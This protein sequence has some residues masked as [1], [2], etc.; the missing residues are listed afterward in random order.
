MRI[1]ISRP[2][3]LRKG[4]EPGLRVYTVG[5]LLCIENFCPGERSRVYIRPDELEVLHRVIESLMNKFGFLED[6][7][8]IKI[9]AQEETPKI[10]KVP[11]VERDKL[12]EYID[13]IIGGEK[14]EDKKETVN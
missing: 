2:L 9:K 7:E 3:K 1:E 14:S 12:K 8:R 11:E 4:Y 5:K 10:P 6:I 13:T